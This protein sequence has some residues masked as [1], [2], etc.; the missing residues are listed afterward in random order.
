MG[1]LVLGMLLI[2]YP[3]FI[4]FGLRHFDISTI[5]GVLA[6]LF[7]ARCFLKPPASMRAQQNSTRAL[8]VA[9]VVLVAFS[10]FNDSDLPLRFYPVIV[11][12]G[13][14]ILFTSTILYPPSFIESLARLKTPDLPQSACVYTRK[15][16]LAWMLFFL[17]NGSIALYTAVYSSMKVWTFYNGFLAYIAMGTL[18]ALE[19]LLRL[20]VRKNEN[21]P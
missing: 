5:T 21:A 2:L 19:F 7:V 11:N 13:M 20:Y 6:L 16:T 8:S 14:F 12:G 17:V 10:F 3:V 4:F 18:F 9:G 15:V 1:S